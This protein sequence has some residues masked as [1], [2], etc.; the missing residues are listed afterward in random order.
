MEPAD[1]IK[2]PG[3]VGCT[4][5]CSTECDKGMEVGRLIWFVVLDGIYLLAVVIL[6]SFLLLRC[7]NG[8]RQVS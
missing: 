1:V 4:S 5:T 7:G 8:G 6:V 3:V 2:D